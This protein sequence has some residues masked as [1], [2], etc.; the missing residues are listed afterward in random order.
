MQ[1]I[2]Q[3]SERKSALRFWNGALG[4]KA[5]RNT[6]RIRQPLTGVTLW[7]IAVGVM[8]VLI[9]RV[10]FAHEMGAP[11]PNPTCSGLPADA[12]FTGDPTNATDD[13][14]GLNTADVGGY[15]TTGALLVPKVGDENT[16]NSGHSNFRYGKITVPALTAGKLA[17]TV[18]AGSPAQPTD[19]VLCVRESTTPVGTSRTMYTAAHASA[20]S[21]AQAARTAAD[22]AGAVDADADP[23]PT[24][25]EM[26]TAVSAARAAL[27]AV[28]AAMNA[29]NEIDG[30]TAITTEL[31]TVD[32]AITA[33]DALDPEATGYLAAAETALN[34]TGGAE[35][36]LDAA[37]TIIGATIVAQHMGVMLTTYLDA[38][39]T[40][41]VLVLAHGDDTLENVE[42]TFEGLMGADGLERVIGKADSPKN[43]TFTTN[44]AGL[45]MGD[46]TG[47]AVMGTLHQGT[48]NTGDVVGVNTGEGKVMITA[49]LAAASHFLEI[50]DE[51]AG[52]G[53]VM[54]SAW[55]RPS[56][57][58]NRSANANW[59]Q[60]V[61]A[62]Q[63]VYY[64]FS[65][66]SP[67]V[68]TLSATADRTNPADTRA[69]L[70]SKNG[71]VGMSMD[72]PGGM[73]FEIMLPA[74]SGAYIVAVQGDT[75]QEKGEYILMS[76]AVT[77]NLLTI[78]VAA[79]TPPPTANETTYYVFDVAQGGG[80]LHVKVTGATGGADDEKTDAELSANGQRVGGVS[81]MGHA[82]FATQVM[83]GTHLLKITTTA[84]SPPAL[85]VGFIE[86]VAFT[87]QAPTA[88][89]VDLELL[90]MACEADE[91]FVLASTPPTEQACRDAH[92]GLLRT[93]GDGG[94]GG[95]TGGGGG[96]GGGST[97]RPDPAPLGYIEDPS[98]VRSGLSMIRGWICEAP[99]QVR[100]HVFDSDGE[101][102]LNL[103]AAYGTTRG[104]TRSRCGRSN[105]GFG[106]TYNFNLLDEGMYTVQV[107]ADGNQ[108]G[109][110]GQSQT[111]RFEVVHLSDSEF[112]TDVDAEC[113]VPD[114]PEDGYET[115]LEWEES[116]QN[117]VIGGVMEMEE[118]EAQQ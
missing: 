64:Q 10:A 16:A 115:S 31:A 44:V 78:P 15:D 54:L 52:G 73:D 70:Y 24:T 1:A 110:G 106:L 108:I 21:A 13:T 29:V 93:A 23:A 4:I 19:A 57:A 43:Y 32:T 49:P 56:M 40:E 3:A 62:G 5:K 30:V 90:G 74:L 72:K 96:G 60:E 9:G 65:L 14:T 41:Y 91:R 112:L 68:P 80:W 42:F 82:N 38:G 28:E 55:F 25:E 58:W 75:P 53:S 102:V 8:L 35:G 12:F 113:V 66:T 79:T 95:G 76:E 99:D 22:A 71:Q 83:A 18:G 84:A 94:T 34:G 59:A 48:D 97:T 6:P 39:T 69:T 81:N 98:G 46:T 2:K 45:F 117:F 63:T 100:V 11:L 101:R 103:R 85:A 51:N 105:T 17:I 61:E 33:L 47:R 37:A 27:V 26:Q 92:P 116:L 89:P 88:P 36:A 67:E 118:E 77:A 20:D 111:N 7:G 87:N 86:Q 104:D 50:T 109:L 107:L 114:F